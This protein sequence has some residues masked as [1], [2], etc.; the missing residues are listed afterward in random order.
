M[1]TLRDTHHTQSVVQHIKNE[2]MKKIIITVLTTLF[3]TNIGFSQTK[4]F[5]DQA[6]IETSAKV[7]TLVTPDRIF[8]T[9][10]ITEKDTKGKK[11]VEE[12]ENKMAEKLETLGINLDN[13]NKLKMVKSRSFA[14][15]SEIKKKPVK[16]FNRLF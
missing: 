11:S 3:V 13:L 7:D 6:Y 10:L 15:L 16:I 1:H 9:I 2:H 12:L 4:N 14:L 8:L 5:I